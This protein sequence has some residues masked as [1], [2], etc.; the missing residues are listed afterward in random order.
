MR[1]YGVIVFLS[2]SLLL[3]GCSGLAE[4]NK[5]TLTGAAAGAGAGA[6]AGL[7]VGD[8]GMGALVGGLIGGVSGLLYGE[9]WKDELDL[10]F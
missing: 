10:G 6:A 2:G 1:K 3:S 7:A 9:Y 8:P 5:Y 4:E